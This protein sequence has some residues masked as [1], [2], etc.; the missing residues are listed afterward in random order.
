[1]TSTAEFSEI[2]QHELR[3]QMSRVLREVEAGR[4]YTM[5]VDGSPVAD[6]VP[7]RPAER[8]ASVPRA[9]VLAAFGAVSSSASTR[10]DLDRYIDDSLYDP[11]DRA[12]R[13]GAFRP[14]PGE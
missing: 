7:H 10:A 13:R 3:N 14:D 8:R 2:P 4:S 6:L 1:M 12:F 9:E 11:Y 5:T